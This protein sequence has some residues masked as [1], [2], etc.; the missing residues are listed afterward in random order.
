LSR[1][2]AYRAPGLA[3]EPCDSGGPS[4]PPSELTWIGIGGVPPSFRKNIGDSFVA[5]SPPVPFVNGGGRKRLCSA[6]YALTIPTSSRASISSPGCHF[7]VE[8]LRIENDDSSG[9]C[10]RRAPKVNAEPRPGVALGKNR[11]TLQPRWATAECRTRQSL[12]VADRRRDAGTPRHSF[13]F[14]SWIAVRQRIQCPPELHGTAGHPV[15]RQVD[16]LHGLVYA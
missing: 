10:S 14:G 13:L 2:A 16:L 8:C 1:F 6:S 3:D 9:L 5:C 11:L 15:R 12:R 7:T 4:T